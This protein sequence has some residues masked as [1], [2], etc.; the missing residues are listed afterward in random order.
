MHAAIRGGHE[1][2]VC[3]LFGHGADV[4]SR[5]GGCY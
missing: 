5:Y 2:F 3:W 1:G 4:T